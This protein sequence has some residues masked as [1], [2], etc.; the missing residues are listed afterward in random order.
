MN[1]PQKF[2]SVPQTPSTATIPTPSLAQAIPIHQMVISAVQACDADILPSLMSNIV[3]VGG[4]TLF[5]GFTERLNVELT[6][7]SPG[8]SVFFAWV[9][10]CIAEVEGSN[11]INQRYMLLDRRLKGGLQLG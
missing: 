4:T 6:Q 5:P 11:S 1:L 8:V 9:Q 7:E 10:G 3:I 2:L